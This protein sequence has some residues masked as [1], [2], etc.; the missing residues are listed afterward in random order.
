V[1]ARSEDR[2]RLA[3]GGW[4]IARRPR[5]QDVPKTTVNGGKKFGERRAFAW[6]RS[7]R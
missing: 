5:R 3:F 6:Q 2:R 4:I 7:G 1:V